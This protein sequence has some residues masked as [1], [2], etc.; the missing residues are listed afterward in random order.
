MIRWITD[1][2]GTSSWEFAHTLPEIHIVDVRDL[3]D[4]RGNVVAAVRSKITEAV[5][6]LNRGEKVVICCDYGI[7]RSNAIAAGALALFEKITM[8]AALQRVVAATGESG[9][10]L[11]VLETVRKVIDPVDRP[12]SKGSILITG[13]S[14]F[15]GS[16]L[17]KKLL[18]EGHSVV[19]P[20]HQEIDLLRDV[21]QLDMLVKQ[22][23]VRQIVHLAIPRVYTTNESFGHAMVM[24]KNVLDVAVHNHTPFYYLSSWE[25]YSGYKAQQ[26]LADES[27]AA[28]PGST[29]GQAKHLA[30]VLIRCFVEQHGLKSLIIRSSPVYGPQSDRPKFIW[31][32]LSKARQNQDIVTHQYLNGFPALD[33]LYI[34]DL[35]SALLKALE[36][37]VYGELNVGTGVGV[38]TAEVARMLIEKTRSRSRL[39]HT[40]IEEY[41]GNIVMDSRRAKNLLGWQPQ[42]T[43]SQGLDQL[44]QMES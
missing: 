26:L 1:R 41:V 42:V 31:N 18:D 17:T 27:L 10:K 21:I 33:L 43:I 28:R 38:T 2:L 22:Q 15:I 20:S 11:D 14:G 12:A 3:V 32:F 19:A 35:Q 37:G 8:D 7:S 34:D 23:N 40:P 13:A 39:I 36:A 30:E 29:Y 16:S 6:G 44:V 5:E 4:K 24:L 9:I 25:I